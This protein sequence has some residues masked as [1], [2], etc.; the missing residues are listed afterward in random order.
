M[1]AQRKGNAMPPSTKTKTVAG[2]SRI[3]WVGTLS[4]SVASFL[5]GVRAKP[6]RDLAT[7]KHSRVFYQRGV[8]PWAAPDF[9]MLVASDVSTKS[10]GMVP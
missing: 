10:A 5:A 8:A 4:A 2:K 6:Q 1:T 9:G 3:H 7:T